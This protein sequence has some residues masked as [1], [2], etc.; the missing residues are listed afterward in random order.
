MFPYVI[1]GDV[2][3]PFF[4]I[5]FSATAVVFILLS[6]RS[7]R[8][9][10]VD[11]NDA[12]NIP[13]AICIGALLLSKVPLGIIYGWNLSEYLTFWRTGHTLFGGIVTSVTIVAVYSSVRKQNFTDVIAAMTYPAFF[14][15]SVYRIFVCFAVGC[16]YGF[17]SQKYGITFPPQSFAGNGREVKLFPSQIAEALM[18]FICGVI[19]YKLRKMEKERLIVLALLLL[20]AERAVAE[21]IRADIREKLVKIHQIGLSVWFFAILGLM[22]L[23]ELYLNVIRPWIEEFKKIGREDTKR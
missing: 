5:G 8:D 6:F 14:S 19:T 12:V 15:L 21:M 20:T 1:I 16:C 13:L 18:F 9:V 23:S 17:E 10:G 22:V 11:D 4:S 3:L 2:Q 7:L